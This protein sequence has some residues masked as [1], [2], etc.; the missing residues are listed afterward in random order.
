MPAVLTADSVPATKHGMHALM[1]AKTTYGII[2]GGSE[3]CS[4]HVTGEERLF[5]R[6]RAG[7]IKYALQYGYTL[8][9][10]FTFG[11]SDLYRS[12]S[13][14]RPLNLWLVER[15]GFVLPIFAGSWFCPLLPRTDVELHTVMGKALHLPRIDEPTKEDVDHWHA[16]YIKELEALYAE[17]KAQFGYGTRELQI[18]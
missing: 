18:E 13:V 6:K 17:H 3:E 2:P 7:F 9:I 15:F 1:K 10:A 16:M 14:M 12:L 5:L 8:V 4:I 11:E